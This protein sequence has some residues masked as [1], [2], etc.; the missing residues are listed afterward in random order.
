MQPLVSFSKV[1][2]CENNPCTLSSFPAFSKIYFE[3]LFR[4]KFYQKHRICRQHLKMNKSYENFETYFLFY[5][6]V[7]A[8][9]EKICKTIKIY[10][11]MHIIRDKMNKGK[12]RMSDASN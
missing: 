3:V 8:E 5:V 10:Q 2:S 4:Y 6:W 9:Y 11:T 12:L 1:S 7:V